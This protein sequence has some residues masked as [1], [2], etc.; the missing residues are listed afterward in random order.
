[1][2]KEIV[3][4]GLAIAL[5]TT[6]IFGGNPNEYKEIK[7]TM[8]LPLFKKSGRGSSDK[9]IGVGVQM[10]MCKLLGGGPMLIGFG[11][12]GL[13]SPNGEKNAFYV[14]FNYYLGQAPDSV[15][16]QRGILLDILTAFE[17]RIVAEDEIN[18]VLD[19]L[20]S[21]DENE[22]YFVSKKIAKV[23]VFLPLNL[24]LYSLFFLNNQ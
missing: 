19:L 24:P 12:N 14:D 5:A 1:M 6:N 17:S 3:L 18:K 9:V 16:K 21:L 13:F 22:H 20:N 10:G 23:S 4:A 11:V 7:N 8:K 2:K 15:L